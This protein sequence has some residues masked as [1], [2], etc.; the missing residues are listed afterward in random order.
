VRHTGNVR[1]LGNVLRERPLAGQRDS[2]A[3]EQWRNLDEWVANWETEKVVTCLEQGFALPPERPSMGISPMPPFASP[4]G[5]RTL[6][7]PRSFLCIPLAIAASLGAGVSAAEP[8]GAQIYQSKCAACHGPQGEGSSK[9]PQRLEGD[10]SVA[11]LAAQIQ[12]TMPEDKPGTLTAD[13]AAAVARYV[14][15]TFYSAI[16]RE[17]NRPARIELA[18]L[19]VRQ[20]RQVIADLVGSFRGTASW[21][22]ERGLKGEYFAGRRIGGGRRGGNGGATRLDPVVNFD[23]GTEAPVP[24]ITEPHEFSIRWSGSLLAPE[25]GEYQFVVR[26]DHAARLW[27]NDGQQPLIDRWVKSGNDTEFKESLFLVAGRIYPLRLEF[28]KAKQGVDDSDKQKEKPPSKPAMIGLWWQRPHSVLEPIPAR[29]LSPQGA[30]EVCVCSTPFP[31]DDRSYGWERGTSISKA[32]DQAATAAAFET[33]AYVTAHLDE[34]AGTRAED[35]QRANKLN[36]F[37][38]RFAE[39]AFRR[40]LSDELS[41]TLIDKQ[42]AEASDPDAA[43]KRVLLLV[44]KSP[45]FLYREIGSGSDAYDV[46]AR[47]SFGLWDSLPDRALWDAAREGRLATG[48][49]L[50][51][52]AERLLADVRARTKLREFLLTWLKVDGHPDLSKDPH[53]FPE[54]D[55]AV[56]ADLR[57]SL[58][59][60]LD[61]VVWSDASDYRQLLLADQV[62]LNDRLAKFYGVASPGAEFAPVSLDAAH[63]AGV[64]THPYLMANFAHSAESSPIHR[65]VFLARGVLGQSLKPPPEAVAPLAADLH[66]NLTTRE[67]VEL[68]TRPAACMT[69]HGIINPLGFTLEHFD[70]VGR[71]REHDRGKPVDARGSYVLRSGKKVEVDGARALAEFVAGNDEAHTAFV[72]QLFHHLVQQPVRAYGP[73]TLADLQRSFVEQGF[74]IRKLAIQVMVTAAPVGRPAAVAQAAGPDDSLLSHSGVT[75]TR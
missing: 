31:P 59:L 4:R 33:V 55:A 7:T 2:P 70:A 60:F 9:H 67:R 40:P 72:E 28:S 1:R 51:Q 19:T 66:P 73:Q 20:Y 54:F 16:A 3:R 23:F 18:R 42:F 43:V 71:Y 5:A 75:G 24:E 30:P 41:R 74:H 61:H 6:W 47:L 57:T 22:P 25:T 62:W 26:T 44:L 14:H 10:K 63:R 48:E 53:K 65:G 52:Q 35:P 58:E 21:G 38:R 56:I 49:Q 37:C 17:R 36:T 13:E 27:V 12:K 50:A 34:L 45:R 46:A 32:W 64:L 15:E 8:N 68:Q 29:Y 69:C 11:Q 39:R